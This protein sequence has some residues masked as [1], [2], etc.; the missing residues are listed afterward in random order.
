MYWAAVE[1]IVDYL[2]QAPPQELDGSGRQPADAV[3]RRVT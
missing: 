2:R 3:A 1:D